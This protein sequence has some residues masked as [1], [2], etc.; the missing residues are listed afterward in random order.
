MGLRLGLLGAI[1]EPPPT[2][3]APVS[4]WMQRRVLGLYDLDARAWLASTPT[5]I[6]SSCE[7]A[8]D[9]DVLVGT[10]QGGRMYNRRSSS[11]ACDVRLDPRGR[12][13]LRR[14]D[15]VER[16]GDDASGY[17]RPAV[18][19]AQHSRLKALAIGKRPGYAPHYFLGSTN[20]VAEPFA[21]ADGPDGV[22]VA[23][24]AFLDARPQPYR[25]AAAV[26]TLGRDGSIRLGPDIAVD[27]AAWAIDDRLLGLRRATGDE[28][29]V[30]IENRMTLRTIPTRTHN[31][32]GR[33]FFDG[34]RI[35]PVGGGPAVPLKDRDGQPIATRSFRPLV[36]GERPIAVGHD[37]PLG[38][39]LFRVYRLDTGAPLA[40]VPSPATA[41]M[42][43]VTWG[44]VAINRSGT[45]FA[46]LDEGWLRV[47]DLAAGRI[48]SSTAIP[49]PRL[50]PHLAA[51]GDRWIVSDE[52]GGQ[53]VVLDTSGG[54]PLKVD[55]R[56]VVRAPGLPIPGRRA[57]PPG[58][59][60]VRVGL[61]RPRR[62]GHRPA[63]R[64]F[65]RVTGNFPESARRAGLS[66]LPV[67][68]GRGVV[69][70][71]GMRQGFDLFDLATNR[72]V[73]R[74]QLVSP[75]GLSYGWVATTSD[76]L[77]DGSPGAER[78]VEMVRGSLIGDEATKVLHHQPDA[79]R[80]R[81]A[82]VLGPSKR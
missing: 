55:A 78:L 22:K 65:G 73:V 36:E 52:V 56:P 81:I 67:A 54:P 69:A 21:V 32:L 30:D 76:G 11:F 59:S 24:C 74:I 66:A 31:A 10:G 60:V 53:T 34:H 15:E 62:R 38:V 3:P 70:N 9:G 41:A 13:V 58:R 14:G 28:E 49:P 51:W 46:W 39:C 35:Y 25:R 37:Q 79:I 45:Q 72:T 63:D 47:Y 5:P 50:L 20:G 71:L 23:V 7:V 42:P 26:F 77:W 33:G 17:E 29:V 68:G 64:A 16:A 27:N 6:V 40:E 12:W 61:R 4:S 57:S 18:I 80:E 75:D 1:Q 8:F 82:A 2:F 48:V 44:R 43:G 19:V